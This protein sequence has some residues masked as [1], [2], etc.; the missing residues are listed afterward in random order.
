MRIK[1][2]YELA[3]ELLPDGRADSGEILDGFCLATGYGR[4]QGLRAIGGRKQLPL[5]AARLEF[6]QARVI[7]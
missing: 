6:R 1:E 3:A 2:K 7:G 4:K 5:T